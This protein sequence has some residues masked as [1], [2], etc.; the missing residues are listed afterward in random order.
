MSEDKKEDIKARISNM[1]DTEGVGSSGDYLRYFHR[2]RQEVID[3]LQEDEI[4]EYKE[5]A[6]VETDLRKAPPTPAA[7]FKY[8]LLY[9]L[10]VANS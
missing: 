3:S 10:T 7:V 9:L 8:V 1:R 4:K 6:G 5:L 2:A